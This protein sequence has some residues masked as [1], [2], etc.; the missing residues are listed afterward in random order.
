M[1]NHHRVVA[2]KPT[3]RLSCTFWPPTMATR[4]KRVHW[5]DC[6][7]NCSNIVHV[8]ASNCIYVMR[9]NNVITS[10]IRIAGP[11][12]RLRHAADIIW[13]PNVFLKSQVSS[14]IDSLD[15]SRIISLFDFF[16]FRILKSRVHCSCFILRHFAWQSIVAADNRKP[17]LCWSSDSGCARFNGKAVAWTMVWARRKIRAAVLS[18][19]IKKFNRRI[20]IDRWCWTIVQ[21]IGYSFLQRITRLVLDVSYR[22]R[23]QQHSAVQPRAFEAMHLDSHR[24]F[25]NA[26]YRRYG[27]CW[28][29]SQS[30]CRQ[31]SSRTKESIER[32]EFD[33]NSAVSSNDNGTTGDVAEVT[34]IGQHRQHLWR[35]HC[36]ISN[37]VLHIW[38]RSKF[39]D[40]NR[41]C[42][43]TLEFTE[44]KLRQFRNYG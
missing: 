2:S 1:E 43:S 22:T 7:M 11:M 13:P 38:C 3:K 36:Q 12:C 32:K 28:M 42:Q 37:S 34:A 31:H 35:S 5:Q 8:V 10:W 16:D 30:P 21:C 9:M 40:R 20:D 24:S 29:R 14:S 17:R 19:E 26:H 6:T 41:G 23:D 25:A 18:L 33:S 44:S 4:Q 39:I 15:L 27:N